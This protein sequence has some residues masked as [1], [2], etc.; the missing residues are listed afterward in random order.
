MTKVCIVSF[1]ALL[2]STEC[3]G[4]PI[5]ITEIIAYKGSIAGS[6]TFM[7]L[8]EKEND[9]SGRYMYEKYKIPI[10]LNGKI[11]PEK[12]S[13]LE[14]N[15]SNIANLEASIHEE[16]LKGTWQDTKHTYRFEV[17]ARSRSYKKI[18]DRIEID[19]ATQEKILNIELAT[20]KKQKIKISTQTNPINII[21]EDLNFDGFPDMRILE[22]EAGGNSAYSYYI[23]D[24][25]NGIYSPAP[26]VFERLTS[27]V[28]SHYQKT[29]YSVSKDGCCKYSSEQV[30]PDTLRHAEY[31]Y[32]SQTGK[33]TLTN[34]TTGNKTQRLINRAEF[35]EDYLDKIPQL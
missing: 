28:V 21:F 23:Y 2:I 11:T 12:L 22:I 35:E 5:E 25:K 18:I 16:T 29:I 19:S 9:V 26:A 3:L 10:S 4:T 32:V 20:G 33:E 27:P 7:V 17:I 14:S 1:M 13:L 24:L 30:L 15:V 8:I 31:D 34:R 6:P